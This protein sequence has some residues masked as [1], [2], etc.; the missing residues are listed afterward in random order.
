[1]TNY[2]GFKTRKDALRFS[3]KHGGKFISLDRDKKAEAIYKACT[4]LDL[5][6]YRFVVEW[7]GP[8]V[9]PDLTKY[10]NREEESE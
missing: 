3:R 5:N 1:M 6:T 2:Q 4:E 7:N 8:Y 10:L 9:K